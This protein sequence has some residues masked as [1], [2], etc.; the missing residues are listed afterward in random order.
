MQRLFSAFQQALC[1]KIVVFG[2]LSLS[3]L[4]SLFVFIQQPSLA[5]PI[6]TEGEKLIQQEQRSKASGAANKAADATSRDQAYKEQLEA[7]KNPDKVYENNLKAYNDSHPENLIDKTVEG[8]K[9]V[10]EKVTGQE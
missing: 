7:A 2:M 5:A 6:S 3:I 10:I 4:S 1:K 9:G 8:A